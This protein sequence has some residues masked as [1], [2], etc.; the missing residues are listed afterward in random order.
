[1]PPL[2]IAQWRQR[3]ISE[4]DFLMGNWLS[5]TSRVLVA[6]A[7]GLGKTN[8]A[9]ALGMRISAGLDFLH[10]K[11]TRPSRVL[12]IDGEM[13]SR[14]LRQRLLDEAQRAGQDPAG[15]YGLSHEDIPNFKP[16]NTP[17]GQA[18]IEKIVKSIG[19]IDLLMAD[20]VMCLLA[21]DMKDEEPWSQTMPWIRSL[22][23]RCIGQLWLHHTGHD[24]TKGYGTK[25]REWQMDTVLH[26]E[27]AR[28]D[29]TDVSF[30][31]TFRKARERTPATRFDFQDV[32]VALVND[33]WEHQLTDSRRPQSIRPQTAKALD[34]LTNVIA[35]D[36]AVALSGGRRSAK[37]E[38]WKAECVHM[39]LIDTEAKAHSA[40][41]LFSKFRRELVA[42]NRI[43]CEG[44]FSW[45]IR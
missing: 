34:A 10:W 37:A 15:F 17:E 1:L 32:R 8:T 42:A 45:L 16:L 26:L 21:G 40:R 6:A 12:Y 36:Q 31:L 9:I 33:C 19:G 24:E 18:C 7:T 30:N 2:T 25:T 20:S 38:D 41:T 44:D 11:G 4:P 28:R 27:T 23:K 14:L 29:D 13:S 35:T 39:G 22:T 5:T 3:E 43:A